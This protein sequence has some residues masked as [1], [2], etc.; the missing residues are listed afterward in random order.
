M[1]RRK[2]GGL[3]VPFLICRRNGRVLV[4]QTH[5]PKMGCED[6]SPVKRG[7][8]VSTAREMIPR[9]GTKMKVCGREGRR[10]R[11]RK[12]PLP[13]CVCAATPPVRNNTQPELTATPKTDR[14]GPRCHPEALGGDHSQ[15]YPCVS[16][17]RCKLHHH[18]VSI[19][20]GEPTHWPRAAAAALTFRYDKYIFLFV[21]LIRSR[22]SPVC[23][24]RVGTYARH[25]PGGNRATSVRLLVAS[26]IIPTITCNLAFA[27]L[28]R[29]AAHILLD[30]RD[31]A[32]K[33]VTRAC[34]R[35]RLLGSSR[36]PRAL[37]PR[38]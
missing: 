6:P 9:R 1:R 36:P 22:G 30:N 2:G 27:S 28:L 31:Y 10:T 14:A 5:P 26:T 7:Y 23:P 12:R 18:L 34:P 15:F 33:L 16:M 8:C 13:P 35:R 32:N 19:Q 25:V 4:S 24:A 3:F 29:P 38:S 20:R 11:G 17:A 21:L 37:S